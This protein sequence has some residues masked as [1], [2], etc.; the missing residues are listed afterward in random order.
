MNNRPTRAI[1]IKMGTIYF[2]VILGLCFI[3]Q[4]NS[5]INRPFSFRRRSKCQPLKIQ[6]CRKLGYN[7]TRSLDDMYP[8]MPLPELQQYI[9][10]LDKIQCSKDLLFF[11]CTIYSPVCFAGYTP[12]VLPCRSVCERVKK[13]CLPYVQLA[14]FSWPSELDCEKLPEYNTGVCIRPSAI[15]SREYFLSVKA[16]LQI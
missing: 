12:R 15:V 4:N 5:M 1:K 13:G 7:Q 16:V 8:S 3:H 11:L 10:L 2:L 6:S 9:K 14:G